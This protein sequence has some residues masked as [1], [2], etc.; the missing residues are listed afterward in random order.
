MKTELTHSF[1]YYLPQYHEIEE[2]NL[3]WG[4]GFTEWT[5]LKNA[6]TYHPKQEIIYPNK[7]LGYYNLL[8]VKVIEKQ[9][10][11]AKDHAIDTF[12]FWH[13]WFDD[14][15]MLLEKP[16]EMILK[17]DIDVNFCF[18]W[19]N[20]SWWNKTENKLLKEQK[21]DFSLST[22]FDYLKPF[23][24]DK[25]YRKIN[26]KPVFFIFDPK[27]CKI[28]HKLIKY[29]NLECQKIGFDGV[30]FIFE[31]TKDNDKIMISLCDRYLKS[32]EIFDYRSFFTKLKNKSYLILNRL[33]YPK[34][35]YHDYRKAIRDLNKNLDDKKIPIVFPN[36]DSTIRHAKG[37]I[38]FFN[39]TPHFFKQ[40]LLSTASALKKQTGDKLVVIKSWN[41]WAE[42]N[43]M[44]PS[45]KYGSEYLKIF[46]DIFTLKN[47]TSNN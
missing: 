18:A 15:D 4:K 8:D 27:N 12:C 19:A 35:R 44:E 11:L 36:W 25:R 22:Y 31:N 2:N 21:Y 16:A 41:E 28:L 6:K 43:T 32:A 1:A 40:H 38:C 13:Y 33:G 26:N 47:T 34:I 20:H 7:E 45:N 9:Y 23:F 17:S 5:H 46:S 29:F 3:W 14:N 39:T 24:L 42:G 30:Y 10:K 37:G